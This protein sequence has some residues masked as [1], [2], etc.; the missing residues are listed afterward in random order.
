MKKLTTQIFEPSPQ[1]YGLQGALYALRNHIQKTN[2]WN[3]TKIGPVDGGIKVH[4]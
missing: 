2:D 4:S 1:P 3:V